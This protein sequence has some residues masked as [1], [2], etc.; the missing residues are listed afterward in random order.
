MKK[1]KSTITTRKRENLIL[2][3]NF[4]IVLAFIALIVGAMVLPSSDAFMRFVPAVT[5]GDVTLS[6][7]E[8]GACYKNTYNWYKVTLTDKMGD[9]STFPTFGDL[10]KAIRDE[11]TGETYAEFFRKL[12]IDK[13]SELY[14]LCGAQ[15]TSEM[16]PYQVEEYAET[17][18]AS[19]E[20]T[21]E[22]IS[23]YMTENADICDKYTY[24]YITLKTAADGN[25]SLE[26]LRALAKDI[27]GRVTGETD[28]ID[29]AHDYDNEKYADDD[30][31]LCV[32]SGDLLNPYYSDFLR[33]SARKY[34][35]IGV[36][37]MPTGAYIVYFITRENDPGAAEALLREKTFA[38]WLTE[39]KP[40]V[41][42]R[43]GIQ[44]SY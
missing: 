18:K 27:S 2:A 13:I 41:K 3:R 19:L 20:L 31:T 8:F 26:S 5:V 40:A 29:Q 6:A 44:F 28:F 15:L 14:V 42:I 16:V 21:D 23:V 25:T 4:V 43:W 17:K 1:H 32:S 34:G 35:D 33:D 30:A 12:T 38:E 7:K 9:A 37:D 22:Q 39:M 11:A 24:R 10:E 36:V